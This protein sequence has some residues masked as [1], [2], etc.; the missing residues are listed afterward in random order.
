MGPS[1][2]LS[3]FK[4]DTNDIDIDRLVHSVSLRRRESLSGPLNHKRRQ[5][6]AMLNSGR[7]FL[8][9][10]ICILLNM[11]LIVLEADY[12]A[13]GDKPPVWV[14]VPSFVLLCAFVIELLCR[15]YAW[16][17]TFWLEP[18]NVFDLVIVITDVFLEVIGIL[19]LSTT[20]ISGA[21][22]LRL[23]RLVK[24]S[25][26]MKA[27][28]ELNMLLRGMA[29]ALKTTLWGCVVLAVLLTLWSISAVQLIY[30]LTKKDCRECAKF[31]NVVSANLAF[32]EIVVVGDNWGDVAGRIIEHRRWTAVFFIAAYVS[33]HVIV[34]NLILGVIVDAAAKA[35]AAQVE[36]QLTEKRQVIQSARRQVLNIFRELDVDGSGELS[37]EEVLEGAQHDPKFMALLHLMDVQPSDLEVV[38]SILDEDDR[39]KVSY[40]EFADHLHKLR[41]SNSHTLLVFVKYYVKEIFQKVSIELNLINMMIKQLNAD[42]RVR[43]YD[44]SLTGD[45]LVTGSPLCAG[46]DTMVYSGPPELHDKIVKESTAPPETTGDSLTAENSLPDEQFQAKLHQLRVEVSNALHQEW[47]AMYDDIWCRL[48]AGLKSILEYREISDVTRAHGVPSVVVHNNRMP[49]L[50]L[51][52]I[53]APQESSSGRLGVLNQIGDNEPSALN[54]VE[55]HELSSRSSMSHLH[56]PPCWQMQGNLCQ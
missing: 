38:W 54:K 33:I 32:M 18:W 26:P 43:K 39:G 36:H 7:F 3:T 23:V 9:M 17:D 45:Q 16:R 21:R 31:N 12:S 25:K 50:P 15:F 4:P 52:C 19:G 14:K 49:S 11:F 44:T 5:M 56:H 37:R 53:L 29:G 46:L 48:E 8:V 1:A 40:T 2:N 28:P 30:P 41:S 55:I 47:M 27:L 20:S 42:T 10:S 35:S 13:D 51:S 24:H 22:I 6:D 34:L